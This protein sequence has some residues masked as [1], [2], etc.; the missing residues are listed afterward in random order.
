MRK[1][2]DVLKACD[3]SIQVNLRRDL[4]DVSPA[5]GGQSQYCPSEA[6]PHVT[7]SLVRGVASLVV[8]ACVATIVPLLA[9][10]RGGTGGQGGQGGETGRGVLGPVGAL[11]QEVVR[12]C[13][14]VHR[15]G[16]PGCLTGR[17]YRSERPVG[18][19]R[20]P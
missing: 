5:G 1:L 19:R 9:Q 2:L 18:R 12:A 20:S 6:K 4:Q 15:A 17:A 8:V 13:P 3:P 10:G 11:G 16:A 14:G 7:C